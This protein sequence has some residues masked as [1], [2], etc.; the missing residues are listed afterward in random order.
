MTPTKPSSWWPLIKLLP[1][2]T[3]FRFMRH[4][5]LALGLSLVATL[6]ALAVTMFPFKPPCGRSPAQ[7]EQRRRLRIPSCPKPGCGCCWWRTTPWWRMS[8]PAST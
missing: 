3:N 5:K 6:A 1:V 8:S 7:L 2:K 4:A